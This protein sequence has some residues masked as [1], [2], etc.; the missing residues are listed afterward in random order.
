MFLLASWVMNGVKVW[1]FKRIRH[2]FV[3]QFKVCSEILL[4]QGEEKEG[5]EP[6]CTGKGVGDPYHTTAQKLWY[7]IYY[8]HTLSVSSERNSC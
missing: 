5:E 2:G 4:V 3:G 6:I 1:V 8:N 7:S